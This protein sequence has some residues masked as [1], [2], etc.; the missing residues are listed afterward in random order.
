MSGVDLSESIGIW[1]HGR[2]GIDK[3]ILPT[4]WY[5]EQHPFEYE[6]VVNTPAGVHKIFENLAIMSNNVQPVEIDFE[7]V[8][9]AYLFNKA[10]IYHDA[11]NLYGLKGEDKAY[12]IEQEGF[13]KD[14]YAITDFTPMFKNASVNYDHVLDEYTIAVKQTCKNK[15]SY[16]LRLGNIQYKEDCWFTNIE[17]LRYNLKLN[18]ANYSDLASTDAF[19]SAKLRDK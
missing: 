18:S 15:E 19:G 6:F 4:K 13:N 9:D 14:N 3:Q 2:T 12:V 10:R 7:F 5:G 11:S 16:G 17:P 1:K 8:G